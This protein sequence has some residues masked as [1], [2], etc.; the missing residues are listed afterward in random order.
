MTGGRPS[1]E[2]MDLDTVSGLV[3]A[4]VSTYNAALEYY[5]R[6]QRRKWQENTYATHAKGR[7][8]GGGCCGLSTSL[9][10]SAPMIREAYDSGVDLL[11]NCFSTGDGE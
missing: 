3:T 5:T 4:I 6:W 2:P 1:L 8:S 7:L 9:R 11:G 10:Y